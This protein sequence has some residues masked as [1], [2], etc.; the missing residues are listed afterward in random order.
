MELLRERRLG[1]G[2][3][4]IEVMAPLL[5]VIRIRGGGRRAGFLGRRR[6]RGTRGAH[7]GRCE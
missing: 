7:I 2:R 1:R 3:R 4:R 6:L 5:L